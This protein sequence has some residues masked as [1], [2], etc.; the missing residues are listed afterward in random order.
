[1][2][3]P[4][5]FIDKVVLDAEIIINKGAGIGSDAAS[6]RGSEILTLLVN[7]ADCDTKSCDYGDESP[8]E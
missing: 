6:E 2:G 5:R 8:P 4:G 1:M 7:R 3:I